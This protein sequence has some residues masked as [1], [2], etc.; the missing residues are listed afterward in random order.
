MQIVV[1]GFYDTFKLFIAQMNS[2]FTKNKVWNFCFL[3]PL[4]QFTVSPEPL[5]FARSVAT[6]E[7]SIREHEPLVQHVAKTKHLSV[8]NWNLPFCVI[9]LI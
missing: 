9:H 5:L 1:N 2:V 4:S 7:A 8:I 6:E 3:L